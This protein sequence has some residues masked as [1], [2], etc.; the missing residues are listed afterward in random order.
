[1]VSATTPNDSLR[2]SEDTAP[3][4]ASRRPWTECEV[5]ERRRQVLQAPA[6]GR[7]DGVKESYSTCA[8][9]IPIIL[10]RFERDGSS[11]ETRTRP[12][13]RAKND[14]G[15]QEHPLAAAPCLGATRIALRSIDSGADRDCRIRRSFGARGRD[16]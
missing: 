3:R 15:N 7:L 6:R 10:A 5:G 12:P 16:Q 1:M 14:Y 8:A 4:F 2:S 11:G 13:R 9:V